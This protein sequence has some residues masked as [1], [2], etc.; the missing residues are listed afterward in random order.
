MS[1]NPSFLLFFLFLSAALCITNNGVLI[2]LPMQGA[3]LRRTSFT[4]RERNTVTLTWFFSFCPRKP[5]G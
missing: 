2:D 5:K 4:R 3:N 1:Y